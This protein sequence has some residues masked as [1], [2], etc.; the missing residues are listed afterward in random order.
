MPLFHIKKLVVS[1]SVSSYPPLLTS[2]LLVNPAKFL[3]NWLPQLNYLLKVYLSSL[4]ENSRNNS[5]K[6][7]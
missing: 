4:K 1:A 3:F 2:S 7:R 5:K 6:I